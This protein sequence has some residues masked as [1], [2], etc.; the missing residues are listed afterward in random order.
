MAATK[1]RLIHCGTGVVPPSDFGLEPGDTV[2]IT[3]DP[4]GT[5]TNVVE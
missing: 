2:S 5:L 3:I 4:I 1:L